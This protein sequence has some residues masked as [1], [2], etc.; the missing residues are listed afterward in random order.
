MSKEYVKN[1]IDGKSKYDAGVAAG[2][3][4]SMARN[5]A[6]RIETPEVRDEIESLQR[7]IS[8]EIDTSLL[9]QKL[10]EGLD[11]TTP[12]TAQKDGQISDERLYPDYRIRLQYI[13]KIALMSRQYQPRN[14]SGPTGKD[15]GPIDLEALTDEELKERE[16]RLEQELGIGQDP[17]HG[18]AL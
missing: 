12:K 15:G 18:S 9:A 7:A 8:A 5:A 17:N 6:N 10:R 16:R 1:R 3:S 14:T 2:F 4:H 11:A 13:E